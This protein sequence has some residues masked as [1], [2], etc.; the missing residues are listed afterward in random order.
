MHTRMP[1]RT[2]THLHIHGACTR[3][4]TCTCLCLHTNTG[5]LFILQKK[6]ILSCDATQMKDNVLTKTNQVPK[7]TSSLVGMHQVSDVV[8][9]KDTGTGNWLPGVRASIDGQVL[10]YME[11]VLVLQNEKY[12][13]YNSAHAVNTTIVYI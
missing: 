10:L 11:R 9:S 3:A 7:G 13:L 8:K 4:H 5:T 6:G 1:M 2:C 12:L